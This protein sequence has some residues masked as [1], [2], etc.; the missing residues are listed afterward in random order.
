MT[1]STVKH[2]FFSEYFADGARTT[3]GILLPVL[4]FFQLGELQM[5]FPVSIGALCASIT[6]VPGPV[7]H[8]RNGILA[9]I[10]IV[11]AVAAATGYAQVNMFLMGAAILL[12]SFFFS[13]LTVFSMRAAIVGTA[14]L[15]IMVLVMGLHPANIWLFSGLLA[16]GG[17]WY[18]CL[19]M[20]FL[21]VLP[22]R[23]A[24]HALGECIHEVA[25]TLRLKAAF[26]NPATDLDEGYQKI[27][28]QQIVVSEKQDAVRELLVKSNLMMKSTSVQGRVLLLTFADV[29]D[30]YEQIM[31]I[32]YDYATM[33]EE[34]GHTGTLETIGRMIRYVADELTEI[35]WAIQSNT[36]YR[37]RRQLQTDL[38]QVEHYIHELS[39]R[40]PEV[41]ILVLQKVFLN[42]QDLVQR[43]FSIQNYFKAETG[44]KTKAD[45][46]I[47]KEDELEFSR[48]VTHNEYDPKKLKNNFTFQSAIFRHSLRVA[49]VC[50]S[51]YILTQLFNLGHHSYWI[52]LTI[53]VILKPAFSLTKQRN[54]E[55]LVGTIAGAVIGV[56]ILHFVKDTTAHFILMTICMVGTFSFQRI[57]YIICVIF[58]TPFIL[59]AF[60]F[61]GSGD[62]TIARERIVDTVIGSAFAFA[63]S[64]LVFPNWESEKLSQFMRAMLQA[65]INYLQKVAETLAGLKVGTT[66]YKLARKDVYVNSAN[67]SAA[68][69]RMVSEP[70]KKQR[71]G[72]QIHR[73]LVLNHILSS[74][75]ASVA[76]FLQSRDRQ[77][78]PQALSQPV[79]NSIAILHEGMQQLSPETDTPAQPLQEITETVAAA[80]TPFENEALLRDQL[81]FMQK[82]SQ[83]IHKTTL[84]ITN[85]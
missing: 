27:V 70:K 35:G 83:D 63:A 26:Y 59:I 29:V 34:L 22:Y 58:M 68:F 14:A 76:S 19:S 16:A 18:L 40:T 81:H 1:A 15:L 3:L 2:F 78:Y 7:A 45:T 33:R 36:R 51:G 73:F 13:M 41:H 23:P 67:L 47:E 64:Y 61:M 5:G 60:S 54:Y 75:I 62:L 84:E 30:L 77:V 65:N 20:L 28:A 21:R 8:K 85:Q 72:E 55:R 56:F 31:A 12:F 10:V 38:E 80:D 9:C 82:L 4:L 74:N 79:H 37:P 66:A 53:I 46:M 32:Q 11:F 71:N 39:D 24:Q 42:L 49:L 50:L 25:R 44:E 48:F 52:L 69:Q 43:L 57:N 6:D 17:A